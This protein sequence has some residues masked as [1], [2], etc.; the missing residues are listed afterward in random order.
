[1]TLLRNRERGN[2]D[3][4]WKTA[5]SVP[6]RVADF[7]D[8]RILVILDE[9]QFKKEI[10]NFV[11][12]FKYEFQAQIKAL[13]KEI[14]R[15]QGSLNNLSGK[16]A[17]YQFATAFRTKKRFALSDYFNG[18]KDTTRLNIFDVKLRV[19]L[20]RENGKQMELDVV[21]TSSCGRIVV[22]EVKKWKEP[23]GMMPVENCVD[24]L[25]VYATQVPDNTILPVF[26]A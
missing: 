20:Q 7:L 10:N 22:V 19:L 23:V 15:L 24:K 6:H 12:D 16:F 11:P 21:A 26:L 5:C 3:A 4:M 17:E 8:C 14:R 25:A 2:Y 9:F 18:V 13:K 1:M